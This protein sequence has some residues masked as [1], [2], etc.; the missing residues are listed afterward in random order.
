[1]KAIVIWNRGS[2]DSVSKNDA[3][4]GFV[5]FHQ[6]L[7][8]SSV[9]ITVYLEGLEDG[10]HGFHIHEKNVTPELL[11]L[12]NVSDCCDK[13]GGHFNVGKKWS[14]EYPTGTP[15][16]DHTGDLCMNIDVEDGEVDTMFWDDKISLFPGENCVIGRSLIIHKDEDDLGEGVYDDEE[17]NEQSK[18]TGNAGD[19]IACGNIVL[20]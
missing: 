12:D 5:L 14:P 11:S 19:R 6:A 17:K 4:D 1:M 10:K 3:L 15:H 18:I 9:S 2:K 16:G 7:E 20:L 8:T 13:L